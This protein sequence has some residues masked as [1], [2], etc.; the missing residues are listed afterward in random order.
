MGVESVSILDANDILQ[1]ID[2]EQPVNYAPDNSLTAALDYSRSFSRADMNV[3]LGYSYQDGTV[4]STNAG[5]NLNTDDRGLLDANVS[6]SNIEVARGNL[7]VSLWGKNLAD[8]EYQIVS[9]AALANAGFTIFD[10]STFG[11][12]RT[13][14]LTLSYEY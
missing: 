4:T 3:H 1:V 10:W 11:D 2:I 6:L 13:Y 5:D 12:P 8:E 14:G 7:K 9:T